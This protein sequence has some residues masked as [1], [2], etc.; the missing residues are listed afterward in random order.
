MP[1][2]SPQNTH[3][4][5][6]IIESLIEKN[7]LW[8]LDC[9]LLKHVNLVMI[10]S[11]QLGRQGKRENTHGSQMLYPKDCG[12]LWPSCYSMGQ[13]HAKL[14]PNIVIIMPLTIYSILDPI[15]IMA[16]TILELLYSTPPPPPHKTIII[17]TL[18]PHYHYQ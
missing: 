3:H 11:Q 9:F 10:S 6:I 15:E 17:I 7:D 18:A 1:E 12:R 16:C 2:D 14:V 4:K 8:A 5:K 13:I